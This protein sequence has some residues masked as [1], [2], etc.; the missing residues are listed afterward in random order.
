MISHPLFKSLILWI[1][2]L[3]I[4][5][6]FLY[7]SHLFPIHWITMQFTPPD[8]IIPIL[9]WWV[10]QFIKVCID[11]LINKK[12]TRKSLWTSGGFPSTHGWIT[13]SIATLMALQYGIEST[14]FAI[15]FAFSFLFWYDAI[16]VRYEAGQHAS[17]INKISEELDTIFKLDGKVASLKERLWHTF[18]EVAGGIVTGV[19]LTIMY[20][21]I[22]VM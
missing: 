14:E 13:A 20:H 18:I 16:N 21:L 15:T 2:D 7:F 12:I 3:C 9:V 17:Y 1:F 6:F 4:I 5:V 8:F 22:F 11:F 19:A 10:I